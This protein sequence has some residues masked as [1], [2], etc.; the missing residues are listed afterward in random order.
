MVS[1]HQITTPAEIDIVETIYTDI[2][3]SDSRHYVQQRL[4]GY[5]HSNGGFGITRNTIGHRLV[6]VRIDIKAHQPVGHVRKAAIGGKG[7]FGNLHNL[8]EPDGRKGGV[9]G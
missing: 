8:P 4:A 7:I 9:R 1:Q 6:R 3:I 2:L 5:I